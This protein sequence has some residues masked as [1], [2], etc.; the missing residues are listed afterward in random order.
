MPTP[1]APSLFGTYLRCL[2][3]K[4]LTIAVGALLATDVNVLRAQGYPIPRWSSL[5]VLALTYLTASFRVWLKERRLAIKAE[6]ART[7]I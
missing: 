7:M 2:A 6:T 5:L 1:T 4:W 3:S